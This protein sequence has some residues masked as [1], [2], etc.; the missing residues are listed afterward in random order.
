MSTGNKKA[1]PETLISTILLSVYTLL[2]LFTEMGI[3]LFIRY[4]EKI[5]VAGTSLT[6][7]TQTMAEGTCCRKKY[8][9]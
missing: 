3:I 2:L 8:S 6:A 7:G 1:P 9:R 4:A 5:T